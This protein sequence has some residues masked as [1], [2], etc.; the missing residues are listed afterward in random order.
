MFTYKCI[1][2]LTLK[3]YFIFEVLYLNIFKIKMLNIV[4]IETFLQ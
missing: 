2:L 3:N 1:L 4:L